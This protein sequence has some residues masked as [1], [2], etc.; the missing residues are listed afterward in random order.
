[1][2]NKV[3]HSQPI[4]V[5]GANRDIASISNYI[6]NLYNSLAGAFR[7]YGDGI[8]GIVDEITTPAQPTAFKAYVKAALPSAATYANNAIIVTDDV[9]G[10]VLA[11]SDGTNW[12]RVTDRAIIS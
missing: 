6:V 10:L 7:E 8:N 1:M 2:V 4:A 9:G 5:P 11:F 3:N 12:R